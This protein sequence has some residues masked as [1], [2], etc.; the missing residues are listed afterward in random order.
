[1]YNSLLR[2]KRTFKRIMQLLILFIHLVRFI[3]SEKLIAREIYYICKMV[4]S[5]LSK[6]YN[7]IQSEK[8]LSQ[9]A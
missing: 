3:D 4:S 2:N 7:E 8:Q 5:M 1:M 6:R 9:T